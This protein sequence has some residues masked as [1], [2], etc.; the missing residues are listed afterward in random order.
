[1]IAPLGTSRAKI[2]IRFE[3]VNVAR[4]VCYIAAQCPPL[5]A[6]VDGHAVQ[7]EGPAGAVDIFVKIHEDVAKQAGLDAPVERL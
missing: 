1:M 2:Q 3:N 5:V 7:I 6:R 4:C